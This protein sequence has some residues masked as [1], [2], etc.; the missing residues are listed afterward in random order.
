MKA[1]DF[2]PL[3]TPWQHRLLSLLRG[4]DGMIRTAPEIAGLL[5]VGS[6]VLYD[7]F[8]KLRARGL[9]ER[10]KRLGRATVVVPGPVVVQL[11]ACEGC[12]KWQARAKCV[13]GHRVL[14]RPQ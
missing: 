12:G 6:T 4:P 1:R 7:A 8:G 5:G 2:A 3:V 11:G 10:T 13:C 14:W 9:L